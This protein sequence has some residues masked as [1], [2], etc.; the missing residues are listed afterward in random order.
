MKKIKTLILI[1][2]LTAATAA[3]SACG[4]TNY[5]DYISELRSDLFYAETQNYT[6]TLACVERE[7]PYLADGIA[8]KMTKIVE[9]ILTDN[10]HK[11]GYTVTAKYGETELGGETSYRNLRG[12]NFYSESVKTFPEGSVS[13]TVTYDGK[14]ETMVASSVKNEHTMSCDQVMEKVT[15]GESEL[16]ADMGREGSFE[17]E[18]YIRLLKRDKAYYYVGIIARDGTTTSLLLNAE[19]GETVARRS[20]DE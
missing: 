12:D 8:G 10:E 14:S 20:P 4:K 5:S 9:I 17:G 18:F 19:T 3:L 7:N 13:L 15:A 2:V 1:S 11:S 6:V 16:L